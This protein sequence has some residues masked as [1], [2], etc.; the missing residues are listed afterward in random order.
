MLPIQTILHP[1]DFSEPAEWAFR[2]AC[3]LAE[4]HDARLVVLHV[5]PPPFYGMALLQQPEYEALW[6]DLQQ[7]QAPEFEIRLEH[8]LRQGDR[9]TQILRVALETQCD[10]MVIGSHQ[11]S[12]LRRFFKEGFAEKLA[13]YAPCHALAVQTPFPELSVEKEPLAVWPARRGRELV[14]SGH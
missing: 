2:R 1:T 3:L 7:L 5:A 10:L 4:E 9:L 13:R 12:G 11:R 14:V 8:R 6:K